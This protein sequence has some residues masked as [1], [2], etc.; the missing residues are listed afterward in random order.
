[1][2]AVD[3]TL[4]VAEL[5]AGSY[6][7]SGPAMSGKYELLIDIIIEGF[8]HDDGALIVTTNDGAQ[9]IVRDIESHDIELPDQFRIVDCV[10]EQQGGTDRFSEDRVEYVSSPADLTGIGIG[11]SEQLRRFADAD[12]ERTRVGF[13][14]LSTLLMYAELETVFRFL[15]VLSGRVESINGLGLFAIDPSTHE[16][17][18]VNTLKQLF[19]GMIELRDADAGPQVRIVGV[20]NV[21][22][23]WTAIPQSS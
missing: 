13:Y 15:H 18:V 12:V 4:P 23:D 6:L 16:A 3:D 19:D 2:Y 10:T 5:E 17:D 1:M 11:V 8:S 22:K 21:S 9:K 14:S 20:P 7:L